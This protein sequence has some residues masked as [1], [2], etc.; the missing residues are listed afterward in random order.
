M[1]EVEIADGRIGFTDRAMESE[2]RTSL[3]T[4]DLKISQFTSAPGSKAAVKFSAKTEAGETFGMEGSLSVAPFLFEGAVGI[5]EI[6]LAKYAPYYRKQVLFE[7]SEGRLDLKTSVRL[8]MAG[9]G[10]DVK[11]SGLKATASSLKLKKRDEASNFIEIPL[12]EARDGAMDLAGRELT[13]GEVFSENG[14]IASVREK[15]GELSLQTL[16]PSAPAPETGKDNAAESA[17]VQQRPWKFL[18]RKISLKNFLVTFEDRMISEPATF[19]VD[20]I[21]VEAQNVSAEKESKSKI[22]F[23]CRVNEGGAIQ[24]AGEVAAAPLFA[25]LKLTLKDIAILP[26]QPYLPADVKLKPT[27]REAFCRWQSAAGKIRRR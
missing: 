5:S 16:V 27:F 14:K 10:P 24:V 26:V 18:L 21:N 25:D 3:E 23:S 4:I 22:T 8:D 12:L 11:L 2:F 6:A 17:T 15:N 20:L 9:K 1:D 7:A 13:L 19:L